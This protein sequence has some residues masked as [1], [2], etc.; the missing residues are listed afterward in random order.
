MPSILAKSISK[1]LRGLSAILPKHTKR[2]LLWTLLYSRVSG[3]TFTAEQKAKLNEA[4]SLCKD[5]NALALPVQLDKYLGCELDICQTVTTE[6][7]SG[8][9]S[10]S[11]A[12]P[13]FLNAIPQ[14][15]R[16][17]SDSLMIRDFRS[18]MTML[19]HQYSF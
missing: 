4:L 13:E 6:A 11:I 12:E 5:Q 19:N 3:K 10:G 18:L 15:L 1:A 2:L 7:A 9:K 17:A 14:W 8:E 16:Y